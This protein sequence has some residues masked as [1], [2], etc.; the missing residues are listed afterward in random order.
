MSMR[1]GFVMSLVIGRL[2]LACIFVLLFIPIGVLL[3]LA[4]KDPLMLRRRNNISSNWT[5]RGQ[6]HP[7]DRLF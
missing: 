3:R 4:G 1:L 6:L 2:V 5:K 7:L